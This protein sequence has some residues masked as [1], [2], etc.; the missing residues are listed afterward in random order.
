MDCVRKQMHFVRNLLKKWPHF[1]A[2]A[3]QPKPF[4]SAHA[5]Q[6]TFPQLNAYHTVYGAQNA[7]NFARKVVSTFI[8]S[9]LTCRFN[10]RFHWKCV[11]CV[12]FRLTSLSIRSKQID[13]FVSYHNRL[14]K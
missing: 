7:R 8:V 14:N 9:T 1:H 2:D 4:R 10:L 12:C 3:L 13:L 6:K 5:V 11:V